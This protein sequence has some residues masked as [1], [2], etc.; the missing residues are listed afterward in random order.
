ME[1]ITKRFGEDTLTLGKLAEMGKEVMSDKVNMQI[2]LDQ[3][4]YEDFIKRKFPDRLMQQ[5][6]IKRM[7]NHRIK[8]IKRLGKLDWPRRRSTNCQLMIVKWF[9]NNF[10]VKYRKDFYIIQVPDKTIE[11]VQFYDINK[12]W[13]WHE[14]KIKWF[15]YIDVNPDEPTA[16]PEFFFSSKTLKEAALSIE[17]L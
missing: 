12:Y 4:K 5:N 2:T 11:P 7:P 14:G 10:N 16:R 9:K 15:V 6:L 1:S 8:L 17:A 3:Y 13:E